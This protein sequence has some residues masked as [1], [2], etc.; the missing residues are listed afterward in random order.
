MGILHPLMVVV[1][2]NASRQ[3]AKK[4]DV[5]NGPERASSRRLTR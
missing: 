1:F 3:Q 2:L 5:M 4:N